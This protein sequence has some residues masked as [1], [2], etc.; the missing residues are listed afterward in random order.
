MHG[1]TPHDQGRQL[2]WG[3]TSDDYSAHRP[4]PPLSLFTRWLDH[5]IGQS[6]QRILDL[7]TGTGALARQFAAQGC[8]VS[9]VDIAGPQLDAARR[10]AEEAGLDVD[11]IRT[12]AEE[13]PWDEPTFD[14]VTACQCWLYFDRDRVLDELR[15]ILKQE[16]LI[17]TAHFCWL[18]RQDEIARRTEELVLE[19]NPDW[20]AADWSGE[21]PDCPE[22]AR[23]R[24]EVVGTF[25]YDKPT[26][27]TRESWCGRI[28][29]CRGIG[30]SLSVEEVAAFDQA[31]QELLASTVP[32]QF[33]VLHRIDSH[34]F[35]FR[36]D[37]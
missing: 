28:R 30:A 3:L 18:P 11:L 15:R 12:S 35:R 33:T 23:E 24:L 32:E 36:L 27:F 7:G 26:P 37:D 14:A 21:I 22:W 17:A 10:M 29:A 6:G 8:A 20:S 9:G 16:G 2:D 5:G 1:L 13:L 34:I 31:H 19:F 25:Y 4:G